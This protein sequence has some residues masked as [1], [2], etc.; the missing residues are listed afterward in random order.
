M[1]LRGDT[2][3]YTFIYMITNFQQQPLP[4]SGLGESITSKP[5]ELQSWGC[6]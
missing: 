2:G 4:K 5:I 6:A 1:S 3:A